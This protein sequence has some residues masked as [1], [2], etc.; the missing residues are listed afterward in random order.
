M[1]LGP[2]SGVDPRRRDDLRDPVRSHPNL[3]AGR[4]VDEVVVERAKQAAVGQVGRPAFGPG[5]D[6]MGFAPGRESFTP[7]PDTALVADGQREALIAVE[8][9]SGK[10]EVEDGG[11]CPQHGGDQPGVAREPS[12]LAG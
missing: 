6:V 2:S 5:T 11:V 1:A 12:A 10:A 8:E 3:P 9:P 4:A 7:G